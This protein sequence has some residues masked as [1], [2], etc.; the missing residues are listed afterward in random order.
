[1]VHGLVGSLFNRLTLALSMVTGNNRKKN[2]NIFRFDLFKIAIW[3]ISKQLKGVFDDRCLLLFC[4]HYNSCS[5]K[6]IVFC[7]SLNLTRPM[8][9]CDVLKQ[10]PIIIQNIALLL[11]TNTLYLY[12]FIRRCAVYAFDFAK[13]SIQFYAYKSDEYSIHKPSKSFFC[14]C[15]LDMHS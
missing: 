13:Q 1:M 10:N 15:V 7:S 4:S 8:S 3:K 9:E 11:S 2:V 14:V 6:K 5:K 12:Y